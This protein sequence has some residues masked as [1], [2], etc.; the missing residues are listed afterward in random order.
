MELINTTGVAC[1]LTVGLAPEHGDAK[2]GVITAKATFMVGS[3]GR[4]TLD[5]QDPYPVLSGDEETPLGVLPMDLPIRRGPAF[6]VMML[7]AAYAPGGQPA[8]D[9]VVTLAV[10][11]T[12]RHLRVVG[13]RRWVDGPEGPVLTAPEPFVRMPLTWERAFGGS[14]EVWLDPRS[15]TEVMHAANPRGRGFDPSRDLANLGSA[16]YVAP[17]FPRTTYERLAPNLEDPQRPIQFPT[18]APGPVCFAPT[19]VDMGLQMQRVGEL[20]RPQ[21]RTRRAGSVL[22]RADLFPRPPDVG[23]RTSAA[24]SAGD[25]HRLRPKRNL[26]FVLPDTRPVMD[27]VIGART[28]SRELDAAGAGAAPRGA[29]IL[30]RVPTLLLHAP[31]GER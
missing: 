6:E 7:G 9:T 25:H 10:G 26:R 13:N 20:H 17:G 27:Y 14:A 16:L 18:D 4:V 15:T 29:P 12:A 24:R 23:A 1:E 11:D 31:G 30:H 2:Q 28:G 22:T 8:T 3:N 5:T 21:I 19:A